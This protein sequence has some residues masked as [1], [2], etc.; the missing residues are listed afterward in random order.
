MVSHILR[1]IY[2][3]SGIP[4]FIYDSS[5]IGIN[6]EKAKQLSLGMRGGVLFYIT[7]T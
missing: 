2:E 3:L 5:V 7:V 1:I 4:Y 6:L